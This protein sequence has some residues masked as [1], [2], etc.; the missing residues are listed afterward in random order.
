LAKSV[1][2]EALFA[3]NQHFEQVL[4]NL[5]RLRGLGLFDARFRRESLEVCQATVEETRAWVNFESIE[6]LCDREERDRARFG[7]IRDQGEKK[8]EDPQ[9]ALIKAERPKRKSSAENRGR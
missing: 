6:A 5:D 1:A 3:L 9:D 7:R 8:L 4:H 2:Y